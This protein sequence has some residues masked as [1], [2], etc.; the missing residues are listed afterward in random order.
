MAQ[1]PDARPEVAAK[2][3]PIADLVP[4]CV[5][6]LGE[7]ADWVEITA[8]SIWIG[9]VG[10]DAVQRIDPGSLEVDI[11]VPLPGQPLA[12]LTVGFGHLWVPLCGQ[13]PSLAKI[14]LATG[15]LVA[16]YP[17]AHVFPEGGV[18]CGAGSVWLTT[19]PNGE[20]SG[21]D[22]ETGRVRH[23]LRIAP[24]SYNPVFYQGKLFIS[25]AEGASV[26]VV[27]PAAGS[28][29]KNVECG[30]G[31]RFIAGGG[32][33]VWTLNQQD[34]SLSR[35]DA[36][37]LKLSSTTP[38]D[39]AGLGGDMDIAEGIVWTSIRGVPLCATD[40][41]TGALLR[42]WVGA[43]G[44]SLGVGHGAIWLIHCRGGTVSRISL[45]MAL[46]QCTD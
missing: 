42:Q 37:T 24:G 26:T 21:L 12:G 16:T 43:G 9:T 46:S 36:D 14:D 6:A 18:T 15:D 11:V 2:R 3:R 22:P 32:G 29:L 13:K 39:M 33:S 44:D 23:Q 20:L 19:G 45:E 31:P 10:P 7:K 30:A 28:L 4:D 35:L 34:G 38:Q 17:L 41:R 25:C 5:L 8:N 27:D 1:I 40:L